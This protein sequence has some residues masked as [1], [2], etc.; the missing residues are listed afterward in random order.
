MGKK[1][2]Q[3]FGCWGRVVFPSDG[4]LS[5]ACF[6]LSGIRGAAMLRGSWASLGGLLG[7]PVR[8]DSRPCWLSTHVL[9]GVLG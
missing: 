1:R 2:L 6:V 4:E 5:R 8:F 9:S 3:G 7:V